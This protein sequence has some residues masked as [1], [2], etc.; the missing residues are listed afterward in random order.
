M[1]KL[2]IEAGRT[3]LNKQGCMA[4]VSKY[5]NSNNVEFYI[6]GHPEHTLKTAVSH[7]RNGEFRNPFKPNKNGGYFGVG[8]FKSGANDKKTPESQ[9]WHNMLNRCYDNSRYKE[10]VDCSVCS[11][12]L[13]FQRFAKWYT[14]NDFYNMGY[15]LDKDILIKGNKVYSPSAC[16]LIPKEINTLLLDRGSE[17]WGLPSGVSKNGSSFYTKL[18]KGGKTE[19][20][21]SFK[22][23]NEA[24]QAYVVA[25]EAYV[26][27]VANKW[28]GRIDERV[29]DALMN[30]TVN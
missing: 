3:F 5:L 21:G 10:Y 18:R 26:K 7:L 14:G 23:A 4:I 28:R 24:H 20:I 22:T 8:E 19:G 16:S 9:A 6:E 27:E 30:W 2:S 13:N 29:Y 25:K 11:E 17:I 15:E 1:K 12:W